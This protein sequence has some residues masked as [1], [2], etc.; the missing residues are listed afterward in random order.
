LIFSYL[1]PIIL[2]SLT[3][4]AN[5]VYEWDVDGQGNATWNIWE[6]V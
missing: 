5:M 2:D 4:H 6:W 3:R 1:G